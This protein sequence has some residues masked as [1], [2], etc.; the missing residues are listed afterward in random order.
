MFIIHLVVFIE[1][2]L[3]ADTVCGKCHIVCGDDVEGDIIEYSM[4]DV[5]RFYFMEVRYNDCG[6][7]YNYGG[8]VIDVF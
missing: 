3:S 8:V 7:G 2:T 4:K 1:T 5:N 6:C